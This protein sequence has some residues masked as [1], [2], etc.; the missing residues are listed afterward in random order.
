MERLEYATLT[1]EFSPTHNKDKERNRIVEKTDITVFN[2][3]PLKLQGEFVLRDAEGREF[4]LA[5]RET[6]ALCR[7]GHSANKPFCDG[8]HRKAEF[9]S[10]VK[11]G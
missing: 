9:R 5:G 8:S 3:G 11:A 6:V 2:D 4:D 10:T 1:P 7:C